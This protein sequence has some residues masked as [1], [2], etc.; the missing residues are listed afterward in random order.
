MVIIST[1]PLQKEYTGDGIVAIFHLTGYKFLML[2]R[3]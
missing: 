2:N 1:W 3:N